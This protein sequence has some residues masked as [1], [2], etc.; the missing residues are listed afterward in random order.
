MTE[1]QSYEYELFVSYAEADEG[2]VKGYL[3]KTL[4]DAGVRC[5]HESVFQ[6]GV[7]KLEAFERAIKQSKRTLLVISPE[8]L[9]DRLDDFITHMAAAHDLDKQTSSVIPLIYKDTSLPIRLGILKGLRAT[10]EKEQES[11]LVQLL[12]DL[13]RTAAGSEPFPK[14]PYPGM[15][16]FTSDDGDRFFGREDEI[17]KLLECL[18]KHRF[19]TVIGASGSGKSSLVFAGLIPALKQGKLSEYREW[20]IEIKR[21]VDDLQASLEKLLAQDLSNQNQS[22]VQYLFVVDQFE[23]LF[24]VAN[25]KAQTCQE[26]LQ[27]LITIPNVYI[28]LTVRADF[29]AELINSL[30]WSKIEDYLFTVAS[31]AGDKLREVIIQPASKV[32]VFVDREL[33]QQLVMDAAEEKGVLPLLQETLRLSWKNLKVRFLPLSAYQKLL[34]LG[35]GQ[36]KNGLQAAITLVADQAIKDFKIEPEKQKA[37]ARRIF[38]R[39]IEFGQ[40][41]PDTRR[42]Q[43]VDALRIVDEDSFL[44]DETL[45]HLVSCRLLTPSG[46]ENTSRKVDIA[47]EAL[48]SGWPTL[49]KWIVDRKE[50]EQTRRRLEN[51]AQEWLRLKKKG[52]LL[53]NV[54]LK[55]VK[56]WL[57]TSDATELGYDQSLVD[58]AVA[59]QV[60]IAEKER[61]KKAQQQREL[62]L[63]KKALDEERIAKEQAQK[64]EDQER[65]SKIV[66]YIFS[67]IVL[68]VAVFAFIQYRNAEIGQIKA[69]IESSKAKFTANRDS[70]DAL[71]DAL[72]AGT[73]LKNPLLHI[74]ETE[75]K[76]EVMTVLTE[77]V[78]WVKE[79]NRFEDPSGSVNSISFSPD[80][81]T[82]ASSSHDGT[83]KLWQQGQV[84]QLKGHEEPVASVSFSQDGQI[85]ASGGFDGTVRLWKMKN[86]IWEE[87]VA[88][89]KSFG[90]SK[91]WVVSFSSDGLLGAAGDDGIVKIWNL[92]GELIADLTEPNN[93]HVQVLS[94]SFNSKKP[95]IATSYANEVR[96]WRWKDDKGELIQTLDKDE[97]SAGAVLSVDFSPDGQILAT[98]S[99]DGTIKLWQLNGDKAINFKTLIFDEHCDDKNLTCGVKSVSFSSD[100]KTLAAGGMDNTI[101]L[102]EPDQDS[103]CWTQKKILP[104]TLTGHSGYVNSVRFSKDEGEK[105]LA[106]ASSDNTIKLWE[107]KNQRLTV[108]NNDFPTYS[109]R[110]SPTALNAPI[111]AAANGDTVK[112]WEIK[113]SLKNISLKKQTVIDKIQ[114]YEPTIYKVTFSNN[115]KLFA[116]AISNSEDQTGSVN[117]WK[118]NDEGIPL[119]PPLI[120][121]P[122][123][124]KFNDINFS[125]DDQKIATADR[126]GKVQLWLN[127]FTQITTST[128]KG[129]KGNTSAVSFSPNGQMLVSSGLDGLV[130]LSKMD[131]TSLLFQPNSSQNTSVN[132]V[133]FSSDNQTIAVAR[134]GGLVEFWK[135]NGN[136]VNLIKS[137]SKN[138]VSS[139]VAVV[140]FNPK[141]TYLATANQ[142][143]SIFLWRLDGTLITE[144]IGHSKNVMSLSFSPD[145][146]IL[147]SGSD[148]NSTILWNL[149]DSSE[150]NLSLD[151]WLKLGCVWMEDYLTQPNNLDASN[152]DLCSYP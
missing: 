57:D 32:G 81:K 127:N 107:L 132:D 31:L 126:A 128:F 89:Q 39:L 53:D 95:I 54:A 151:N 133:K 147:A 70:F 120:S 2:W 18:E 78:F 85:L 106:S 69:L 26:S 130:N 111:L 150:E 146:K 134:D 64:A 33:V 17:N 5:I 100:G 16:P 86:N 22:N 92:K 47:H 68:I 61:D 52:G 4:D 80:K 74:E 30:L 19:I 139:S 43:S 42:Q 51:K 118:L 121:Q 82:I 84:H 37:I 144:L 28:V 137:F 40:G 135:I 20:Q 11:A 41:R 141:K 34:T 138:G 101:K 142:A 13:G 3:M 49:Q 110:F 59:S 140:S 50:A 98:G 62:D 48:I 97:D 152:R 96:L 91:V 73:R 72:R 102:W 77:S 15:K 65:R 45:E 21:P 23:E 29:Y 93:E 1:Q 124:T 55:E 12:A 129:H 109:V 136:A 27:R 99:K 148:D 108:L 145:G 123:E 71:L 117:I 6:L 10:T 76:A 131:G 66:A 67:G 9:G 104:T 79:K 60:D 115:G 114:N 125:P 149:D 35:N 14:C 58:L 63:T 44:F 75:L 119:T 143:G 105:L 24:T 83:I 8:Y 46:E 116:A 7:I 94:I 103:N 112:F 90:N 56:D 25:E 122:V 87:D 113:D 38:L 36:Q 88:L